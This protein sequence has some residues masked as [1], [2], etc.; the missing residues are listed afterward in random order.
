MIT[1]L[2]QDVEKK[3]RSNFL[4]TDLNEYFVEKNE[5]RE[6]PNR[7]WFKGSRYR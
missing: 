2:K 1:I 7:I 5:I 4:R 3:R 6:Y